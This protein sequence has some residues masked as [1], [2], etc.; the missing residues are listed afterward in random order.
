MEKRAKGK[1]RRNETIKTKT[2]CQFRIPNDGSVS[3]IEVSNMIQRVRITIPPDGV[4]RVKYRYP[5]AICE[6]CQKQFSGEAPYRQHLQS[7]Q[8]ERRCDSQGNQL[9]NDTCIKVL[10][11]TNF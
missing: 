1:Q 4:M 6:P 9:S 2:M 7:I 8:H 3:V 5:Y 10:A 11:K